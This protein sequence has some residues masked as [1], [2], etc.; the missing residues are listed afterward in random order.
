MPLALMEQGYVLDRVA[1]PSLHI[2]EPVADL[3]L[4]R[5]LN[6][7]VSNDDEVQTRWVISSATR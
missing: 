6:G 3:D 5:L 2:A 7:R 4:Q 1:R